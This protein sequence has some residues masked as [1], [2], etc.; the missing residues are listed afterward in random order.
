MSRRKRYDSNKEKIMKRII[1]LILISM[2]LTSVF[3]IDKSFYG[4][5]NSYSIN[6]Q[7][8]ISQLHNHL[9]LYVKN[10]DKPGDNELLCPPKSTQPNIIMPSF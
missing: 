2:S 4:T 6:R 8:L 7:G 10:I 3:C 5:L 9:V 1:V